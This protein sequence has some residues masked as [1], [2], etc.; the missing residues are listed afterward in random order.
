MS[1]QNSLQIGES[2]NGKWPNDVYIKDKR[3]FM[4]NESDPM[5]NSGR[6]SSFNH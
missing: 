2:N 1:G 3:G 6:Q 4:K 5:I